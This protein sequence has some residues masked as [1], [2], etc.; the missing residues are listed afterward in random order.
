MI[1][2]PLEDSEMNY[3]LSSKI[4]QFINNQLFMI[5]FKNAFLCELR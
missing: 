2:P 4:L 3:P 1:F 5:I